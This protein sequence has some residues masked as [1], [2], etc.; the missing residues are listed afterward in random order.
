[1][2]RR[3]IVETCTRTCLRVW[4]PGGILLWVEGWRRPKR[5]SILL[6]LALVSMVPS[7]AA[8]TGPVRAGLS[9][10]FDYRYDSQGFFDDPER[11]EALE[12][13]GRLVNRYVDQL[14]AIIPEGDNSWSSFFTPPDSTTA[15]I[16]KDLPVPAGTMQIFVAGQPLP[17]RLAQSIDTSPVG[18]GDPAWVDLVEYRGQTGAADEPASDFGPMGGTISFNNVPADV[19]WHFGLSTDELNANEFDFITVAMH[20]I[21]H[22]MG[23]GISESF[24]DQINH[25]TRQFIGPDAVSVGS[26]NNPTL[27]L[28]E[29]EFHWKANTQ[30]FWNGRQQVTLL[31][32][33]I[34]PGKRTFPTLLD[35][36]ALRDIGWEEGSPG[37]AN[38]D[39]LFN[40]D[41]LLVVFQRG[42]YETGQLAGWVDGDWNDNALFESG[43][44]IAALQ[45]G[46]YEQPPVA[47]VSALL[48]STDPTQLIVEYDAITGDLRVDATGTALTAFL[49][50]SSSDL[51]LGENI[52]GL[53]G[54]FDLHRSDRIFTMNLTGFRQLDLGQALPAGLGADLLVADL[55]FD[56]AWLG[57][58]GLDSVRLSI[59]PEPSTAALL[60]GALLVVAGRWRPA[61]RRNPKR[62]AC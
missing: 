47:A 6:C 55:S 54:P 30:S 29:F 2:S 24:D 34:F 59:V 27:E 14:D 26:P 37:D 31:S 18:F 5:A 11:R 44:L 16:L 9:F 45:T 61:R 40:T 25:A 49:I 62:P 8:W 3:L 21:L 22:L 1:M 20:E 52:A 60:T 57:G 36:A 17:Q 13:A 41:D 19:P 35:R 56:G 42:L 4:R 33:G 48:D 46:T 51:F 23:V 50:D 38:L 15:I 28:D 43:D 10:D 58:G 39:R 53:D 32:P 12:A 7:A